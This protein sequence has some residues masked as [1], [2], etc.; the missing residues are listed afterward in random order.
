[1]GSLYYDNNCFSIV[2]T[3]ILILKQQ[4][5]SANIIVYLFYFI[6]GNIKNNLSITILFYN[7]IK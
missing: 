2:I 6:V 4:E 3:Y 1:M 5:F 7:N